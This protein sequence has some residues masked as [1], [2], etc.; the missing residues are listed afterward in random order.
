M[1]KLYQA[2]Y[3]LKQAPRVFNKKIDSYL[4]E[5]G[6]TKCKCEYRVYLQAR[7]QDITL[8][9]LYVDDFLVIGNN[10]NNLVKF[11]KLMVK[12]FEM[13]DLRNMSY[14]LEF[15]RIV[16]GMMLH[17]RKYFKEVLKRFKMLDS[18]PATSH[19]E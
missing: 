17:Q 10:I 2:L 6:F 3:G 7:T 9:C 5:L 14:F 18:N 4:V 8:M 11:K 15:I 16:G 12:E 1:H 19:I 13:P